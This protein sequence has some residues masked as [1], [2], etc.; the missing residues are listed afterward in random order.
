MY[1]KV[2]SGDFCDKFIQ[3][4]LIFNNLREVSLSG[5]GCGKGIIYLG[6]I[7]SLEKLYLF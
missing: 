5:F 2:G 3:K 4:F 1:G 6:K 7:T